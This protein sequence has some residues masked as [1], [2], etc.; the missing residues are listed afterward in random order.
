MLAASNTV[1]PFPSRTAQPS[2]LQQEPPICVALDHTCMHAQGAR[3]ALAAKT[4][5][6]PRIGPSAPIPVIKQPALRL[7]AAGLTHL[8]PLSH[9]P[10][11][12][13]LV[14]LLAPSPAAQLNLLG[15]W[16]A[17]SL[18]PSGSFLAFTHPPSHPSNHPGCSPSS[19]TFHPPLRRPFEGHSIGCQFD[20]TRRVDLSQAFDVGLA[21]PGPPRHPRRARK[22]DQTNLSGRLLVL[23][24]GRL[25]RPRIFPC[26]GRHDRLPSQFHLTLDLTD[27]GTGRRLRGDR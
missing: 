2:R 5:D 18:A 19:S 11:H 26:A 22:S 8:E 6:W 10:T 9:C 15:P 4:G 24:H 21:S 13:T 27:A 1:V 25:S 14:V 12:P 20:R 7:F 23:R 17:G 16:P 3:A